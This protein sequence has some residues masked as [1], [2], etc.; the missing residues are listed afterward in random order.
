[1]KTMKGNGRR[2][3][4]TSAGNAARFRHVARLCACVS[5]IQARACAWCLPLRRKIQTYFKLCKSKNRHRSLSKFQCSDYKMLITRLCP[6]EAILRHLE[7]AIP[8][9]FLLI[10]LQLVSLSLH[11]NYPHSRQ[12][13]CPWQALSLICDF[14]PTFCTEIN[15]LFFPHQTCQLPPKPKAGGQNWNPRTVTQSHCLT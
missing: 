15:H 9:L 8:V 3:R 10:C 11:F 1:M 4:K 12:I 6:L 5:P 2:C 14:S 13:A 7:A